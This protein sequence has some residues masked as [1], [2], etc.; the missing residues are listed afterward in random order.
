MNCKK[1]NSPLDPQARFCGV[2][3]TTVA[4]TTIASGANYA[5]PA[6]PIESRP[7]EATT[8]FPPQQPMPLTVNPPS[9]SQQT[10]P[11]QDQYLAP[12]AP[13][14]RNGQ[15]EQSKRRRRG[16]PLGCFLS[17]ITVLA[18]LFASLAG[19]WFFVLQ[20]YI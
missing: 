14:L 3:G 8:S 20:P 1:C 11:V 13:L 5:M 15:L 12:T 7:R 2:C 19:V 9:L 4:G 17:L 16:S 10:Y 18:L 6:A